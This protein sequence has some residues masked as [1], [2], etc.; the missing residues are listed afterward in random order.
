MYIK[1]FSYSPPTPLESLNNFTIAF[2]FKF[3][4]NTPIAKMTSPVFGPEA[5]PD[6]MNVI[7]V[8]ERPNE[9]IQKVTVYF[10]AE[11]INSIELHFAED[12]KVLM[13]NPEEH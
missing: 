6:G 7:N 2:D 13:G 12:K 1:N 8:S 5:G 3:N 9:K 10:N 4:A 11:R